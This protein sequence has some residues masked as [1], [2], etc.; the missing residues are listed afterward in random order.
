MRRTWMVLGL[1][2]L[3]PF[4]VCGQEPAGEKDAPIKREQLRYDKRTFEE[5][6]HELL[7]ELKATRRVEALKALLAF[8]A[9]GYAAE[10]ANAALQATG[11]YKWEDQ[12]L[13]E[14]LHDVDLAVRR[15]LE[16]AG[17]EV[18]PPL[19][20][21]A[22][23]GKDRSQQLF[24]LG[25]LRWRDNSFALPMVRELALGSDSGVGEE[26]V[27][28][29]SGSKDKKEVRVVIEKLYET[30][31]PE[32]RCRV[33][34]GLAPVSWDPI[35]LRAISDKDARVR[36]RAAEGLDRYPEQEGV[37]PA[38]VAALDDQSVEVRKAVLRTLLTPGLWER[39][40]GSRVVPC[41]KKLVNSE[42]EKE[43]ALANRVLHE[44]TNKVDPRG[45]LRFVPSP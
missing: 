5:W 43:K 21:Q 22:L 27:S 23:K 36:Q 44:I 26:A 13:Q 4:G 38:L 17:D 15:V 35:L 24:V 3:L 20:I 7:T 34:R 16:V 25:Y 45:P 19:L 29:L 41:L 6:R 14:G 8:A 31:N 12:S 1:A 37:F 9:N 39:H 40:Q 30:G 42:D 33:V 2:V 32:V 28:L 10:A 11:A 18:V